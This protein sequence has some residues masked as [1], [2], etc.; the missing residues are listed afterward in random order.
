MSIHVVVC[1]QNNCAELCVEARGR[2][3]SLVLIVWPSP[4]KVFMGFGCHVIGCV[5]SAGGS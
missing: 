2:F 5:S 4:G 3:V 1:A